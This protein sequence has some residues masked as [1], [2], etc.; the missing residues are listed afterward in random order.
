[1][2]NESLASSGDA[3]S[4]DPTPTKQERIEFLRQIIVFTEGNIRAYDIKAQISLA[5]FVLSLN[6]LWSIIN[7]A[8]M[9]AANHQSTSLL[10]LGIIAT[11]MLYGFVLWPVKPNESLASNIPDNHL[12]YIRTLADP[13]PA[14]YMARLMHFSVESELSSEVLK[15]ASIRIVKQR[16][17]K[18][19][20][21]ITALVYITFGS[22]YLL[23]K[24]CT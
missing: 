4:A 5:A 20:L 2:A 10:F 19:A 3:P 22:S 7:A 21:V 24:N 23:L 1:M 13:A 11:I 16:R 8:C 18:T 9:K 15:L 17:L 12:F 6:P 14:T